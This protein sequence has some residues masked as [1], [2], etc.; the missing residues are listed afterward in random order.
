L[1]KR[2]CVRR[3]AIAAL[4]LAM[5]T[6]CDLYLAPDSDEG[7]SR[8]EP[9][10]ELFVVHSLA[11]TIDSVSLDSDGAFL[12]ADRNLVVTGAV[13]N[14]IVR[15]GPYVVIAISGENEVL[16]VTENEFVPSDRIDLGANRNPMRV[17][18]LGP[19]GPDEAR[20]YVA[21]SNL[22]ADSVTIV[23]VR[24]GS[25]LIELDVGPAPQ[26]IVAYPGSSA[27]EIRIVVSNTSFASDRPTDIPFG[28]ATLTELTVSVD[29]DGIVDL[30]DTRT[31][32]LEEPDHDPATE[33]GCN[34][35]DLV[36]VSST[37]ELV[38]VCSGVNLL[39]GGGGSDDGEVLILDDETFAISRRVPIG[40]SPATASLSA[41]SPDATLYTAGVDGIRT[42]TR[43]GGAGWI[44][45]VDTAAALLLS[46]G[47]TGSFF[48]ECVRV[49][50]SLI[51][52][53][54]AGD[55]I[56][57]VDPAS[58]TIL[59]SVGTSDGPI[60]ILLDDES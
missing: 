51:I 28:P 3:S 52:A 47:S 8:D 12:G 2:A 55:R 24:A 18:P 11:E 41:D 5:W 60:A 38:V 14:D 58:G 36:P 43:T 31:I 29:G 54:F 25:R 7:R 1:V 15:V 49:D 19:A 37:G 9:A 56:L 26:A 30:I 17:T 57:R 32:D 21:A 46:S 20:W 16:V 59:E 45:P 34:P 6:G 42:V 13:P 10:V 40:G 35:A 39:P 48:S 23:D 4:V 44:A 33:S 27:D 50:S 22:L 53:D